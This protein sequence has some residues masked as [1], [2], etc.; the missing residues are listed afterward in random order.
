MDINTA[1][2]YGIIGLLIFACIFTFAYQTTV[3]I[4][5][6]VAHPPI[7]IIF[8]CI[9]ALGMAGSIIFLAAKILKQL[10]AA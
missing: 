8:E 2:T 6:G 5:E 10:I 4:P 9:G 3:K 7:T 1:I